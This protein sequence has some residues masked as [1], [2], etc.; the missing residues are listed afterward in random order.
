MHNN[1]CI[2][3]FEELFSWSRF[4]FGQSIT[5]SSEGNLLYCKTLNQVRYQKDNICINMF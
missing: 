2:K 5:T 1:I 4:G 3:N